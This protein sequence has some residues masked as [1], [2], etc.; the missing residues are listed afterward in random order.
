MG[1]AIDIAA[2]T[3]TMATLTMML[4]QLV[5]PFYEKLPGITM[6]SNQLL[7]DNGLRLLQYAINF[8]L[9]MLVQWKAPAGTFAGWQWWDFV[10]LSMGQALFSHG[11]FAIGNQPSN[12]QSNGAATTNLMDTAA[13]T[14][15]SD[16]IAMTTDLP[17]APRI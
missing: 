5:K 13:P 6:A 3:A 4:V 2:L 16:P 8:G 11:V 9:L 10:M 15:I 14:A 17:V 12:A 7:H 1:T